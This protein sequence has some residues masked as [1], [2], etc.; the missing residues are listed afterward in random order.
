MSEKEETIVNT[1]TAKFPGITASVQRQR[2]IWA[3]A[4]R[5]RFLEVLT[6]LHDELGFTSLCTVAGLDLGEEFQLIYYLAGK[7]G[8]VIC[9]KENAP[10]G[11][12]V[13]ETATNLYKGGILFELEARNL[14]GLRIRG[15]PE[16]IRYPLPDNWPEGQYPLRKDWAAPSTAAHAGASTPPNAAAAAPVNAAAASPEVSV[17][18]KPEKEA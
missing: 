15:I 1:L 12:P 11:D 5:E 10:K 4:P 13:F 3:Q 7:D 8:V 16:D 9:V 6:C 14:L 17:E 18:A 2:R